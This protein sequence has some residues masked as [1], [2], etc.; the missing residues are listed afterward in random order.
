[1]YL[2]G[3]FGVAAAAVVAFAL[4]GFTHPGTVPQVHYW[5][6][7]MVAPALAIVG[8]AI[9]TAWQRAGLVAATLLLGFAAQLA[10]KDPFWF[11][12]VHI[13]MASKLSYAMLVAMA[14]QAATALMVLWRAGGARPFYAA[15]SSLGWLQLVALGAALVGGSAGVM[16]M[17]G[18]RNYGS[19]VNQLVLGSAFL[20]LNIVSFIALVIACPGADARRI[21]ERVTHF[22]SLPGSGNE[23]GVFDRRV[24]W[25]LALAVLV[26]GVLARFFVFENLPHID[27][28]IYLSHAEYFA[29]GRLVLP[30]PA[31]TTAFDIYMMNVHG[32]HWFSTS[33]PGWPF[34]LGIG[35]F[36]GAAWIVNP[37]LGAITVLLVHSLVAGFEDRK[38]ANLVVLL[39]VVS[40]WFI[41]T[42]STLI[43]HSLTLALVL[44]AWVLL[45]KARER[46]SLWLPFTAG[47]LMGLD[48]LTRPLEGVVIGG[49]TGLWTLSFLKDRRQLRTVVLY[50]IG[51][52]VVGGL[53]FAYNAY[54]TGNALQTP[55][56][57]YFDHL[58][59]PGSNRLGFGSDI[60]AKPHWGA[61]DP[62]PGHS[63]FEALIQAQQMYYSLNL[64][65]LGF[66]IGSVAFAAIFLLWG[67]R[68]KLTMA[69]SI[70]IVAT[71][72][73]QA[74]YWFSAF[75]YVGPRY[76]YMLL[77]P[78]LVLSAAGI[79]VS[80]RNF[81]GL[82][83]ES[84]AS[85]RIGAGV[86]FL[87]LCAVVVFSSWL[88]VNKYPGF[89]GYH[90]DYR[91]LSQDERFRHA[92]VF[93]SM[94]NYIEYE[95]A[96][97]LNDFD[98]NSAR[99]VFARD[100]GDTVNRQVAASYPQRP[101]YFVEGRSHHSANRPRVTL[102]R[103]PIPP[104]AFAA[105][106]PAR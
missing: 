86:A 98:R 69:M 99:P 77:V 21:G 37:L 17:I 20:A 39:L 10:F 84:L 89:R 87:G 63:P 57:T 38:F 1:M 70:V 44:G 33:A 96:F 47:A 52:I 19:L 90:A 29:Q 94:D 26:F 43:N 23:A 62:F 55:L 97:W 12:H 45:M 79:V 56:N 101:V 91:V 59:G 72:A 16:D 4:I 36:F 58:W 83:P 67:R 61:L 48:F 31:S 42:S 25:C 73:A 28:V 8:V 106:T 7:M 35:V 2:R 30:M 64:E 104:G 40:P 76:W 75:D 105:G 27:E 34:V 60:G 49:L 88:G 102:E 68:S 100:L 3:A 53:V 41:W 71:V 18:S 66:A 50:V 54:L 92:L 46:P 32:G 15:A 14:A 82:F 6:L 93:V 24:P 85:Y 11:Q 9:G 22:V 80:A 13:R 95:S 81:D 103:G 65:L 74:L 5:W 51:C 78:M